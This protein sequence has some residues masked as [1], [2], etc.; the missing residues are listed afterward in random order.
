MD[1]YKKKVYSNI[2]L[3][4]LFIIGVILQIFGHRQVGYKGLFIQLGSLLILILVL[5][6]Y[7]RRHRD[8]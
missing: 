4:V 1:Y 7:N 3:A 5:F 6:L 2:L 8:I